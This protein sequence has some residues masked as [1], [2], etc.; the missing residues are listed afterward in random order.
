MTETPKRPSIAH[1]LRNNFLTGLIICAPV[2]ITI[3]I[4][5]SF[6][7]WAD[8][9]VKPY[10]PARFS[11]DTYLPFPVP[12]FGLLTALVVITLVG[13]LG[14][15]LIGR[16]IVAF[17]E[18]IL[19][20]MP[21][22]RGLYKGLKQIFTSVLQEQSGSF[23]KAAMIEYPGPGLWALVFV[24]TDARGEI[25]ARFNERGMEMV[26]V[27]LPPSPLPTAGFIIFVEKSKLMLLDMSV[28][29]AAKLIVSGG[30]VVPDY[31]PLAHDADKTSGQF[32]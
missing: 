12:G 31:H 7:L 26:A 10:F 9:W 16:S 15:N 32:S 1:R 18:S 19:H 4:S 29:D 6:I 2:A 3:W 21:L 23:K 20:R 17:G 28:E 13:F 30:I 5:W 24:A 8:S 14:A 22:V 27:F 25:A 11:P